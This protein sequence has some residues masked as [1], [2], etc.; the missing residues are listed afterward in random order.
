M[1]LKNLKKP[2]KAIALSFPAAGTCT[3][4][5]KSIYHSITNKH[6]RQQMN[7]PTIP[8]PNETE[9]D[10]MLGPRLSP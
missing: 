8:N 7:D 6:E 2:G 1:E 5:G 10:K 3:M 9:S 4:E